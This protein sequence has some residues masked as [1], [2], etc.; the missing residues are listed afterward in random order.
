[1]QCAGDIS[2]PAHSKGR[3]LLQCFSLLSFT[4][5]AL[6]QKGQM[7]RAR[8]S[9]LSSSVGLPLLCTLA[10]RAPRLLLLSRIAPEWV[11]IERG[12]L[13]KAFWPLGPPFWLKALTHAG[14]SK[15]TQFAGSR[16]TPPCEHRPFSVR[17]QPSAPS[18]PQRATLFAHRTPAAAVPLTILG[19]HIRAALC[20]L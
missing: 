12:Y 17:R 2:S 14:R 9:V 13:A 18:H 19:G 15:W 1:M 8:W 3:C 5:F 7:Q 20:I 10:D 11:T 6:G 4:P 16:S